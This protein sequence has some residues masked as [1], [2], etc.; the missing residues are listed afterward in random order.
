VT[1]TDQHTRI[2]FHGVATYEIVTRNG[3]RI[4][5]EPYLSENPG[6]TVDW[7]SFDRVDLVIVSHAAPDHLGDADKLALKYGC[8][9]VCGGEVKAWLVDHGVPGTQIQATTWG[10]RV[11]CA[12]F[13]VQPLECRHWSQIRLKDG[14][15]ISGTPIAYIVYADGLRF[16]HYGD[17]AIFSDLKL[18][19]ELY[20]PNVGCIGICIPKEILHRYPMPGTLKTSEMSPYEGFLAAQWLGL[21]T[22][23]PCHYCFPEG[24]EDLAAYMRLHEDAM[25]A[26]RSPP[27][28][29]ILRGGDWVLFDADGH[30]VST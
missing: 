6:C 26:G 10:I 4:L 25:A 9:V 11:E 17:T 14:S 12:G 24:D 29:M 27:H 21:E 2:R 15:F 8:P 5:C 1:P 28:P 22:V 23:F 13:D 16:Y 30:R 18:H 7:D 3:R 20:R 19:G